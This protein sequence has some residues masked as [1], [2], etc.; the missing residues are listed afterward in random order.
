MYK[1]CV[2]EQS[3]CRQRELEQGVLRIMTEQRYEDITVIDLCNGL[4]IPRKA[5][6]RYFSNKEGALFALIDHTLMDFTVDFFACGQ[7]ATYGTLERFFVFWSQQQLLLDT[8]V[9]NELSGVLVQRAIVLAVE[10]EFFPHQLFPDLSR[11]TREHVALFLVSGLMSMVAQWHR[12]HFRNSPQ[13]MA[14]IA[15]HL[16][17]RP[18]FSASEEYNAIEA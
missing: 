5:F 7:D 6:Y 9:R 2:T 10:E 12:T 15:A 3:A 1:R 16:L 13:K 4:N 17:T 18:L 11:D 14:Q 8:L